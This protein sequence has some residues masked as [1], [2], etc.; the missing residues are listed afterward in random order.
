MIKIKLYLR[1]VHDDLFSR[2]TTFCRLFR[3]HARVSILDNTEY[4]IQFTIQVVGPLLQFFEKTQKLAV[5]F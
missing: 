1:P 5:D 2:S 4:F 3:R